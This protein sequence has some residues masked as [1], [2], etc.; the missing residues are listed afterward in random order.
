MTRAHDMEMYGIQK[1]RKGMK[2]TKKNY[3][4]NLPDE[5]KLHVFQYLTETE[6]KK[7]R[8]LS[9]E[10]QSKLVKWLT[11][12]VK[13]EDAIRAHNLDNMKWI[14]ER[15]NGGILWHDDIKFGTFFL[16]CL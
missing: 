13:M 4:S 6:I 11:M 3:L 8:T 12:F 2:E 16:S 9:R 14:K 5:M 1:K 15:Y 7:T 10:F